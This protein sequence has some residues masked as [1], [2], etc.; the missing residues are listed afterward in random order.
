M[1][2]NKL[3]SKLQSQKITLSAL[4]FLLLSRPTKNLCNP[5]DMLLIWEVTGEAT[6]PLKG[7]SNGF[8]ERFNIFGFFE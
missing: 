8:S 6:D 5:L 7:A 1:T 3:T 4:S 2:M